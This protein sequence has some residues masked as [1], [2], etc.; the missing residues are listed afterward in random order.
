MKFKVEKAAANWYENN[1]SLKTT[2]GVRFFPMLARGTKTGISI[3]VEAALP[4]RIG[5]K[6]IV[7]NITYFVEEGDKW[8]FNDHDFTITMSEEFNEPQFI[9]SNTDEQ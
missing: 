6:D 7:N 2:K 3:G 8:L 9:L 4:Q 5:E 1:F